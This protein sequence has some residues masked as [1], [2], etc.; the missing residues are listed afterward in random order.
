[1]SINYQV[2]RSSRSKNLRLK[3]NANGNVVVS[4]P[5][6]TT[7]QV[8]GRFVSDNMDWITRNL[9][10]VTARKV[11]L[12]PDQMM[13]FGQTYQRVIHTIL[14]RVGTHPVFIQDGK[15]HLQPVSPTTKSIQRTFETFL[16]TTAQKYIVP[17]TKQLSEVMNISYT[18]LTLRDQKT[19]WGSCSSHG[20]LNFNWRLVQYPTAVIDYVI[21]H[22][23][24][25]RREMN[26]SNRFWAIVAK[27]D[28]E[29]HSRRKW[30]QRY[31]STLD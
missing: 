4:A 20:G 14:D 31:G 7:D 28:P 9:A 25:H 13:V 26:H 2:Q 12:D 10:K 1:M 18:T 17:R 27:F 8:I 29:Y 16:K 30:L 11:Q 22:E 23:L 24:A 15:I 19:R 21:I 5:P 3:I 6:R